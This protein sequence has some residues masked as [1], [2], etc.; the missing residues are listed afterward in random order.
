M[1]NR[2]GPRTWCILA[3]AQPQTVNTVNDTPRPCGRLTGRRVDAAA[4]EGERT[5]DPRNTETSLRGAK[6]WLPRRPPW[7]L[8]FLFSIPTSCFSFLPEEERKRRGK[9]RLKRTKMAFAA[10]PLIL[11]SARF[12]LQSG[13]V[14]EAR[15]DRSER[16]QGCDGLSFHSEALTRVF[17]AD[18]RHTAEPGAE[19]TD[20]TK[21]P[22]SA[23]GPLRAATALRRGQVCHPRGPRGDKLRP[24]GSPL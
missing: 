9:R 22:S 1:A 14:Y 8:R 10:P 16:R 13:D 17:T 20:K 12:P 2:G 23:R 7:L 6:T 15:E 5:S 18:Q 3:P 24:A 21:A 11:P 19:F 4:A